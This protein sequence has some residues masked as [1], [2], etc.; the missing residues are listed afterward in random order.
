MA[1]RAGKQAG[2]DCSL[3][4]GSVAWSSRPRL[5]ARGGLTVCAVA[6]AAGGEIAAQGLLLNFGT[7][8]V[9][10][11]VPSTLTGMFGLG[12]R[13]AAGDERL[14]QVLCRGQCGLDVDSGGDPEPGERGREQLRRRVAGPGAE[15][16][17]RAVDLPGPGPVGM[18][19]VGYAHCRVVVAVEAGV[20][21]VADLVQD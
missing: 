5:R 4:S 8:R 16:E 7:G 19:R 20:R 15:A 21:L 6:S 17:Q 2:Q 11:L 12:G 1:Q 13:A 9:V 3:R 18:D 14:D 10:R